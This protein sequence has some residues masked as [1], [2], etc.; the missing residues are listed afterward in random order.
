MD[1][2]KIIRL[3]SGEDIIANYK[4]DEESGI[5]QVNRPMLLFFKRLPTGKSVMM[6]GPWLPVELI[7]SNSACLYVQDILTVISPRQSL[8][9]Y[10][11]DAANEAELLLNEQG[12]EI[13]QSLQRNVNDIDDDDGEDDNEDEFNISEIMESS[14]GRTIH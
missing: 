10:Y 9:K 14:K 4:E 12:E 3:Q 2:V 6:M 5:V 11:N 1:N 7:Q 8:V 13:E